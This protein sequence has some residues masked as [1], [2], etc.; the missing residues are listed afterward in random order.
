LSLL[1]EAETWTLNNGLKVTSALRTVLDCSRGWDEPWGLAIADA[2]LTKYSIEPE[3]LVAAAV[4]RPPG[5]GT[6]RT[7]WVAE[8]ARAKVESPLESLAR[9]VVVK[10]G[11]PEPTPQVWVSTRLGSFRVDLL[12]ETNRTIIEADGKVKYESAQ[13][14][15]WEKR[16][17][18]ALRDT[19][20]EMTR[21]AAADYHR[22]IPWLTSYRAALVRGG[23][24]KG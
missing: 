9:G 16:R 1:S 7:L 19:G 13:D 6:R 21:F 12:D 18:D 3:A 22:S 14:L 11:L 23:K 2:A 8:H 20:L 24:W 10:A 4:A 15:W 5:P 17:E